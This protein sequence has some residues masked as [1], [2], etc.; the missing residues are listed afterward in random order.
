MDLDLAHGRAQRVLW[1]RNAL[2]FLTLGLG[3]AAAVATSVAM[4]RERDVILVPTMR[5]PVTLSSA[6]VAPEYLEMVTRDVATVALNRSPDALAYWMNSILAVTDEKARGAVKASLIKV[7]A[8]QQGSQITQFFTP[9][10]LRVYPSRLQSEVGGTVHT[11]VASKEVTSA[12]RTFRFDWSYNGV[13][14][15]L[16]GFGMVTKTDAPK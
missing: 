12:H 6:A 9:D 13:S 14:L 8:E 10:S 7:V 16:I 1:Q 3:C 4:T 15:K 2:L 11:V 5:A